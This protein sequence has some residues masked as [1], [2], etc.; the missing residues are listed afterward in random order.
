ME[1][2]K[3]Q[4]CQSNREGEKKTK[5]NRKCNSP[6]LQKILQSY[7]NQN[8]AVCVQTDTKTNGIEEGA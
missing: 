6:R 5:L 4:N 7:S 1:P 3:T 8:T 2:L